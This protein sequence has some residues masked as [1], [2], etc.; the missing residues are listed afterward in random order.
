MNKKGFLPIS[1]SPD[2]LVNR[3][4]DWETGFPGPVYRVSRGSQGETCLWRG[5]CSAMFKDKDAMKDFVCGNYLN[6][7]SE[8]LEV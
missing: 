6:Q 5:V 7:T 4:V 2:K 8:L 3:G 1:T